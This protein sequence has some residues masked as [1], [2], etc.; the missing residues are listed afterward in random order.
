MSHHGHSHGAGGCG[1]GCNHEA[2]LPLQQTLEE[3]AFEKGIWGF[4]LRGANGKQVEAMIKE[5]AEQAASQGHTFSTNAFVNS[6][7]Q[8]GYT[9]LL[10]ASRSGNLEACQ[11]L[12]AYGAD[13]NVKTPSLEQTSL[14]RAA[15]QGH[16]DVVNFL[17]QNGADPTALDKQGMTALDLATREKHYDIVQLL[18]PHV[19]APGH[20]GNG[21]AA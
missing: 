20:T 11:V 21:P 3:V 7:D 13:V 6:L 4:I 19:Q 17:L 10:Y 8:S 18:S 14:H 5:K 12:V 2:A 9:P 15:A 1:A 16:K